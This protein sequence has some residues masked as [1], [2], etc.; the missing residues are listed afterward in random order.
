MRL[1]QRNA[2]RLLGGGN[3]HQVHMI[4]HEAPS[5]HAD[6]LAVE[7]VPQQL[8]VTL[9][10]GAGFEHILPIIAALCDVVGQSTLDESG[11]A[12]HAR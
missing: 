2:E 11:A 10:V 6:P 3:R 9:T 4:R 8:D 12:R 5:Q 7:V 1:A